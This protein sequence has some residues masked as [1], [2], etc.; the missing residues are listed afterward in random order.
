MAEG[1]QTRR[2]KMATC[3][4]L[5]FLQAKN[6]FEALSLAITVYQY[7]WKIEKYYRR[8]KQDY[9]FEEMVYLRYRKH[10]N[11]ITL[12]FILMSSIA[13]LLNS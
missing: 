5:C 11:M 3:G 1:R 6:A 4:F 12:L 10:R 13:S 2:E 9:C 8:V 7:R